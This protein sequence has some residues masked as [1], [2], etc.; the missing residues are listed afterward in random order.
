MAQLTDTYTLDQIATFLSEQGD[1]DSDTAPV[2]AELV[3]AS[4]R[5]IADIDD[6]ADTAMPASGPTAPLASGIARD[7]QAQEGLTDATLLQVALDF[8]DGCAAGEVFKQYLEAAVP[9]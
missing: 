4:G 8:L 9:V 6:E 7:I 1:W 3:I 5:Y 2:I